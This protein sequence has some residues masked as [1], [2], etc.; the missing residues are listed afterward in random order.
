MALR[1]ID[2]LEVAGKRVLLRLDL[3]VPLQDGRV[4][5]DTRVR[6]A[7]PTVR[8]LVE[9][10]AIVVACSH[11]G[12]AKGKVDPTLSL[13]PVA[14]VLA[15]HAGVA[16]EFV[17]DVVGEAAQQA[18]TAARP[19]EV[20]LLE[21]LRFEA[22]E[23]ANDPEFC[24]RLAALADVFVNDAFGAAH[25]EH[26]STAGVAHMFASRGAGGLM[27]REVAALTRVRDHPEHP[28]VAVIGGAKVSG[29]LETL[30]ALSE[31]ADT[32]ALVGGMANTFLLATG[33][34]VGRSRIETELVETA[35]TVLSGAAG[36]GVEVVIPADVVIAASLEGRGRTVDAKDVG[37]D[38]LIL[39][40][41][42]ATRARIAT[43]VGAA[44]TVFWNG[45]AG[46][47]ERTEFAG[48][49]MAIAEAM[50]DSR[51]F[52]V[53]GGGETVA[54]VQQAGVGDQLSHVS[55]GGGAALEFLAGETLPGIAALEA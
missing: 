23:E 38:D 34:P 1:S 43:L 48:G 31:K 42:P 28:F 41:G 25:R 51:A 53:V 21:N 36:R 3:N 6:E 29:K 20:I 13:R 45:P 4:G 26:A 10:G 24:R 19:G 33:R 54:A 22:G 27:A 18:V 30:Q 17:A 55:T 7:A 2:D 39:D 14:P 15:A 32:L 12:R 50:A 9:R 5:D 46:V 47:F 52:T 49:T 35:R 37:A 11:L 16:V 8:L 44:R 40:I